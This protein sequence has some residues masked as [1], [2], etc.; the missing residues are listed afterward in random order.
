MIRFSVTMAA[1][2]LGGFGICSLADAKITLVKVSKDSEIAKELGYTI[3]LTCNT[4]HSGMEGTIT[5]E[6]CAPKSPRLQRLSR[7]ILRLKDGEK[8]TGRLP[9]ELQKGES[10]KVLCHFQLT[11]ETAKHGILD[12]VCPAPD[13]PNGVVYEVDLS[14]YLE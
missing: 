10:G 6:V 9:L 7:I 3:T 14:T 4:E 5:F 13:G 1:V 12:M 11:R 2:V 8:L